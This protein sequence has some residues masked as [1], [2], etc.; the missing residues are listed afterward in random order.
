MAAV[1]RA[2]P[3]NAELRRR[4]IL[5]A[6]VVTV[7][8]LLHHLDHVVPGEIVMDEGLP[9]GWNHSGWPFRDEVAP[10]TAS[11][12]VYVILVAGNAVTLLRRAWAGYWLAASIVLLAIVV[13]VHFLGPEA[14]TPRVIWRI[15]DGGIGA[16]LALL[17][18]VALIAAFIGLAVQA[19]VVRRGSGRWRD[20]RSV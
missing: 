9:D 8:A 10:F 15:Y 6:L 17:D 12:G 20:E 14:E 11:S 7:L 18:L 13:F 2:E 4:L 3:S 16:V 19:V 5:A 1:T